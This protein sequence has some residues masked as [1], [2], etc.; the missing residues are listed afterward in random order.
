LISQAEAEA[1]EAEAAATIDLFSHFALPPIYLTR[2]DK[3]LVVLL[4]SRFT[5][6]QEPADKP[7]RVL[8]VEE[9]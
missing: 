1:A 7:K 8:H 2:G 4:T 3:E 9:L 6:S 5:P